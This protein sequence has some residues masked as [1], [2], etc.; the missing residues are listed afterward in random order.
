MPQLSKIDREKPGPLP[1][2]G[3]SYP[4]VGVL[5]RIGLDW[6]WLWLDAQHGDIDI[7]EAAA[8]VRTAELIGRPALVRIPA[9]YPAWVGKALDFGAAG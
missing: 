7:S 1:G 2:L 6:D 9:I 4:S 3:I 8:L 5:E